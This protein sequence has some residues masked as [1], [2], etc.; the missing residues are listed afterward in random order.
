MFNNIE[1]LKDKAFKL[2]Y[3][4]E[5]KYGACS[6]ATLRALQE[7]YYGK[8]DLKDFKAMS[9]FAAGIGLE[10]DGVCGG[11]TAGVFFLSKEHGREID[12]LDK[13]S[14]DLSANKILF[15]TFDIIKKLHDKFIEKYGSIVCHQIHRKLY[16]RPY[17]I[18]DSDE[19]RKFDEK[20]AHD[21]GCTSVCGEAARFTIEIFEDYK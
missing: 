19:M 3:N 9:G 15:K 16:G 20:G 7:V 1:D 21:W 5:A 4:Y 18:A 14:E 6:Q 11:Y 2:A 8:V 17:Y 10:G 13:D 12:D